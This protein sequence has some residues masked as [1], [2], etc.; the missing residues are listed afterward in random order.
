MI[1]EQWK[2]AIRGWLAYLPV[3]RLRTPRPTVS[4]IKLAGLIGRMGPLRGAG[5]S[6][7]GL[8]R[9]IERAFAA[10]GVKA[11]ALALNSPGGSPVQSALI[12]RRIRQLADD[13]GIPVVAF[14]E[15]VAASGGYWLAC[16]ADEIFA[17]DNSIV[18]SVGVISSGFGFAEF[19]ARHGIERRVHSAGARKGMLDPFQAER[20][21]DVARLEKIQAD[22]HDNFKELVRSSRGARLKGPEEEIFSGD[23]WSA[24]QALALGLIDGIGDLRTVMRERFGER[25]RFRPM[26][27]RKP[28]LRRRLGFATAGLSAGAVAWEIAAAIEE[29]AAWRRFGL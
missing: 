22:I 28:L 14:A 21:D 18:G 15:D 20:I 29:W 12:A 2:S 10:R 1:A 24:R 6:L 11:V 4:V 7:E 9:V 17:D 8:E 26:T 5:L 23:V 19:I 16:A 13:K 3:G 25:V 27:Q